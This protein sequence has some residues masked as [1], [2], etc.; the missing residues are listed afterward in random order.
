M[1]GTTREALRGPTRVD[2]AVAVAFVLA[3]V[4]EAVARYTAHPGQLAFTAS[5]A[6]WLGFLAVRRRRPLVSI[7]GITAGGLLGSIATAALWP[8]AADGAGVWIVAMML[9]SYSLGAH[10]SGRVVVLG[11]VLPL[12]VVLAADLTTMSGW[13]RLSGVLF[14]TLFVGLLPT[15][16]G[17]AV[18]VRDERVR[19]LR[20]QHERIVQGQR[21]Q[22]QSAVLA[23]RVQTAEHLQPILVEGLQT[24]AVSAE[25][26]GDP[27]EIESSARELLVRTREEVVALTAPVAEAPLPEVPVADH[28]A[29]LRT[30]AQPWTVIGGGAVVAGLFAETSGVL[31]VSAPGWVV[32]PAA[33]V[34]GAP[35]TLAW[36]RPVTSI[37]LTWIAVTCYSRAV[38]PLDGSL[39]ETGFALAAAFAVAALSRRRMAV[40]GLVLC[41]L[42]QLVGVG[43]GD[44]LGEAILILL[45]WLGGLA[46]NEAS[47]LVEQTHANNELL[48]RQEASAA[49]R[50]RVEERLRLAQEIHDAIGHSLTVVAL[51]AGAARRLARND[52]E[53]ARGVMRTAAAA[54][55]S[56][57]ASLALDDT[58]ADVAGL[59]E[60]VRAAGLLVEAD[61]THATVEPAQRSVV[62]RVVQEGLTNVLRHA[63]GARATIAVRRHGGVV[64]VMI[65]NSAAAAPGSGPGT[66]LGLAGI[67]ERVRA[68]GGQVTWKTCEDG[69]FELRA[70]LPEAPVPVP[71]P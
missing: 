61:L 27:G 3:A 45:S 22:Q 41:W 42:G 55:R 16:V 57:V 31:E 18:G 50:A 58:S 53:R 59:V 43:A 32:L 64:E 17:R 34:V 7:S 25:S 8:D 6:L 15:A 23:E 39:S 69:G 35:L 71:A 49:A 20:D 29:A 36:W 21:S 26:T 47:R 67:R 4:A 51:Q 10:R 11:V 52:P 14:V 63:P 2:A 38:A 24:L 44:P 54:A 62:F 70:L 13:S 30:A 40:A 60:R 66:G 1:R 48:S 68:A 33:L 65:A 56:G 12:L 5:G 37:A 19:E 9:A 46:L 28:V